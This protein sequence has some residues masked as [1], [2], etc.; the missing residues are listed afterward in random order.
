MKYRL[1]LNSDVIEK[2][3]GESLIDSLVRR[4][5]YHDR[6]FWLE[7]VAMGQVRVS[8][9]ICPPDHVL[10]MGEVVQFAID[11]FTEP[12]LD[13]CYHKI[14]END[15]LIMV[16]KPANLP[17]HSNRRF[18][19]QT[20]TA[21][22]RRNENLPEINP[23]HRLDRETSGLMLYLKKPFGSKSLRR[24]LGQIIGA[25][26]YLAVVNGVFEAETI[27]VSEPLREAGCPPVHYLM[28]VAPDGKPAQT[29]FERLAVGDGCSLV[30]ARLE[31]G[32]KHQIRAHLAHIGHPVVGDKLYSHGGKYFMKRCN[33]ELM[34]EDL[35]SLGSPHQ[36]L[37]A[38]ALGLQLP[39]EDL[40]IYFSDH[41]SQNW[42]SYLKQFTT[43]RE[44]ACQVVNRYIETH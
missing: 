30:L 21:T 18:Y 24:N 7:K 32:R 27:T 13:T 4:F 31:T 19:F 22:L 1:E 16:S 34:P 28:V 25:K 43:W 2:F 36:L 29:V 33:D 14:W 41:F 39:D 5:T 40:R 6:T 12:D 3:A 35:I 20:M 38:W 9:L 10:V 8:G 11:D 42:Q 17:V 26:F 23:M 44:K 37:H 15:N